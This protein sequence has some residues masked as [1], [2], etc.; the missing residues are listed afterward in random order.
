MLLGSVALF[1][2]AI[3]FTGSSSLLA[4]AQTNRSNTTIYNN[5]SD[6]DTTTNTTF[7]NWC[8]RR[9]TR[10]ASTR[11]SRRRNFR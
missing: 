2:A 5:G 7:T 3:L 1:L 6:Y 10:T 4:M 11:R 9:N 8:R